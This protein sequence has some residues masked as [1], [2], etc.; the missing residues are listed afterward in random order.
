MKEFVF[1]FYRD[2]MACSGWQ[3]SRQALGWHIDNF[4]VSKFKY[5]I[6]HQPYEDTYNTILPYNIKANLSDQIDWMTDE[7]Y[8]V[9]SID[10][11]GEVVELMEFNGEEYIFSISPQPIGSQINYHFYAMDTNADFHFLKNEEEED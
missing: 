9:Y 1:N 10:G 2:G 7:L 11:G 8:I 6:S 3:L 5:S 4:L